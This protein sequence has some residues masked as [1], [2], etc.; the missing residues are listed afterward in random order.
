M[1]GANGIASKTGS[2]K[3][4]GTRTI[5]LA[6]GTERRVRAIA[7]GANVFAHKDH[8]GSGFTVTH[9]SGMSVAKGLERSKAIGL[10]QALGR[11]DHSKTLSSA[12]AGDRAAS[13]RMVALIRAHR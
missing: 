9:S 7:S 13:R 10:T 2:A 3:S 4:A 6:N 8:T 11:E 12:I 5:S 1:A